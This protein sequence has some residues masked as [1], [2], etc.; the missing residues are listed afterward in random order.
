MEVTHLARWMVAEFW[1][2]YILIPMM[3]YK[4][5]G[6]HHWNQQW[7]FYIQKYH[8]HQT[9][10]FGAIKWLEIFGLCGLTH[11]QVNVHLNVSF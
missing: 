7:C 3:D 9:N 5:G 1:D 11:L 10:H 2:I 4:F 8:Q 6:R